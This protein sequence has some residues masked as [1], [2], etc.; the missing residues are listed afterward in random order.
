VQKELTTAIV[1]RIANQ[2]KAVMP[3]LL[4]GI[5]PPVALRDTA[6]IR[7]DEV[8]VEAAADAI[9]D[10][11]FRREPAP[12]APQ[13]AYAGIPVH[14]LPGLAADDERVLGVAADLHLAAARWH[15]AVGTEDIIARTHALGMSDE[16]V[17]ESLEVLEHNGYLERKWEL[18][19]QSPYAIELS[20]F[21]LTM[22]LRTARPREYRHAR[23]AI[24]ADI[25]NGQ[26]HF[27]VISSARAISE[28]LGIAILEELERSALL[29]YKMYSEGTFITPTAMLKRF[30]QDLEREDTEAN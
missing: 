1:S 25:V 17:L 4:D 18:G 27:N 29:D 23:R 13:P 24:V 8:S 6:H 15:P 22:F 10:A 28:P 12:V 9:R 19:N 2:V 20:Q 16:L 21:A 3:V 30:L 5:E 7:A 11:I 14:R 26:H